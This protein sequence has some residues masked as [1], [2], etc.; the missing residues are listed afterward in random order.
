MERNT[1]KSGEGVKVAVW[2]VKTTCGQVGRNVAPSQS[3]GWYL[4]A[5][6]AH[7]TEEFT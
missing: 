1:C 6:R 2:N 3:E 4:D 7:R 5:Y